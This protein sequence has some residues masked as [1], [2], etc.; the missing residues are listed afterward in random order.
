MINRLY[1][2]LPEKS[3]NELLEKKLKEKEM[4]YS[5]TSGGMFIFE[6]K[7]YSINKIELNN[8]MKKL[9]PI[10]RLKC[11]KSKS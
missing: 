11:F 2:V 4:Q 8:L 1:L 10:L 5:L 3:M 9:K 7:S 6:Y